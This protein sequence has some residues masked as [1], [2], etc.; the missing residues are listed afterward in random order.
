[1]NSKR[2]VELVGRSIVSILLLQFILNLVV[3]SIAFKLVYDHKE[4][5][6]LII[7]FF[8]NFGIS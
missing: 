1:M 4:D 3:F 6:E 8:Q 5:F 7:S 2:E